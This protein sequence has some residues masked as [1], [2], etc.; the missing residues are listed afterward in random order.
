MHRRVRRP[1]ACRRRPKRRNDSSLGLLLREFRIQ[2]FARKE[3]HSITRISFGPALINEF[4]TGFAR[5]TPETL[6]SDFGKNAATSLGI[7]GINVNLITTGLPNINIQDFT[8]LSGGPAFLPV[9]PRQTHYQFEDNV[10]WTV[11]NHTLKF[12]YRY[13]RRL[14]S[15]FTHTNTR[16]SINFNNN[17]TND[18]TTNTGGSGIATLLTGY[19]TGGSRGF[20]IE[21]YYTTN[22]EHALFVQ[23]DY[24]V[25]ARLML[26]LGVRYEIYQPDVEIRNR[27]V[28]FDR[29]NLRLAYA[30][31]GGISETAG[32]ETRWGNLGP[33]IGFA[34]DMFGNAKTV[35][36]GRLRH[37]PFSGTVLG[38]EP[39]GN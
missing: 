1:A 17:F 35:L 24:K 27:L 23:D 20:L 37:K 7:L 3:P 16:G 30:G 8:G 6:Q 13:V 15:P 5:T 18:P 9:N 38:V 26:N 33:R 34:W 36:T 21:P 31:E 39:A 12:G 10:Y 32:K 29:T 14:T 2:S 22:Q 19:S 25:N 28:N 4:R 11:N